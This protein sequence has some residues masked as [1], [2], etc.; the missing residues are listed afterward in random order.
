MRIL[1]LDLS[2]STPGFAVLDIIDG[3]PVLVHKSHVKTNSKHSHGQRLIAI[4]RHLLN[5]VEMFGPLN[6][7]AREKGFSAH[8]MTTQVI[9]RVVGVSDLSLAKEGYTRIVDIAPTSVKKA[10]TGNGKASKEE[11]AEA[12]EAYVGKQDYA[13]NDES[14]AV[15]V[16][17]A[18]AIQYKL[19]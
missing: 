17:L 1:A 16:G 3:K 7:V 15:A 6:A 9:F 12:V 4:E 2:M 14:D 8:A 13:T 18:Y 19:I 10:V 5:L 11:V